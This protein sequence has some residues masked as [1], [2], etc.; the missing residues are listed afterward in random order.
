MLCGANDSFLMLCESS[1]CHFPLHCSSSSPSVESSRYPFPLSALCAVPTATA[2]VP[3]VLHTLG[4][5]AWFEHPFQQPS[6]LLQLWPSLLPAPF[7]HLF[8][9]AIQLPTER[10][11]WTET[12]DNSLSPAWCLC[13]Q[14]NVAPCVISLCLQMGG[15]CQDHLANWNTAT[16]MFMTWEGC[17]KSLFLPPGTPV[18]L[19]ELRK[20]CLIQS[21][22]ESS[23]PWSGAA[24][25]RWLN[26]TKCV[27]L[28]K[29]WKS[30]ICSGS[31]V[32][33]NKAP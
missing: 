29:Q 3:A 5:Q 21:P 24:L 27:A 6:C 26:L 22:L 14:G 28:C 1:G 32:F 33:Y 20:A 30:H 13:Y 15:Q 23:R 9:R 12:P 31:N 4:A 2:C 25:R 19:Q 18:S 8:S 11:C 17:E 16:V 7:M 10:R